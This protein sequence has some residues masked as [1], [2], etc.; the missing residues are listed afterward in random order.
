MEIEVILYGVAR[1]IIGTSKYKMNIDSQLSVK[2]LLKKLAE[3]FPKFEQLTS[4][5]VAI[6]DEYAAQDYLIKEHD[7]V[8][9]I[10]PVSGG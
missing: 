5:L 10:P 1:D 7:E 4:L 3:E 2:D 8:V 6:N 9:L